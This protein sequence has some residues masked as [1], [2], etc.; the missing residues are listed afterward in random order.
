MARAKRKKRM[1]VFAALCT[2]LILA[3]FAWAVL[4]KVAGLPEPVPHI[5]AGAVG[6]LCLAWRAGRR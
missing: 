2:A 5:A 6:A 4:T 1:N 3:W